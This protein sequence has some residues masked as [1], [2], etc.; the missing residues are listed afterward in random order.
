MQK[1]RKRVKI[2][3]E[4]RK[5]VFAK[6]DGHCAYCGCLLTMSSMQIDH[7][8]AFSFGGSDDIANL[9]PACRKCNWSKHNQGIEQL[10]EE[11]GRYLVSLNKYDHDYQMAKKYGLI[12]ETDQPVRFY[13]EDH[14]SKVK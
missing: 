9:N 8:N 10:R 5:L 12:K 11:I 7:I 14:P 2:G 4:T 1:D 13:Y 6:Y 3:K